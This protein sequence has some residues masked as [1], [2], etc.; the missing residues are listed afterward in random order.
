MTTIPRFFEC[1]TA[2]HRML[3]MKMGVMLIPILNP[4][5]V[6]YRTVFNSKTGITHHVTF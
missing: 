3:G 1:L 6:N 5:V 2:S 4:F